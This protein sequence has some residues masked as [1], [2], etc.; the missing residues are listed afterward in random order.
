MNLG[1]FLGLMILVLSFAI[2]KALPVIVKDRVILIEI[3]NYLFYI[4]IFF[5]VFGVFL[6]FKV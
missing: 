1:L 3:Q 6:I 2:K 4:Q 5:V